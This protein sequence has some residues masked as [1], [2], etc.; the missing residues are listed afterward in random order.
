MNLSIEPIIK[1][2]V[3]VLGC[4]RPGYLTVFMRYGSGL[5]DG[6]IPTEIP[7]DLVPFGLR[8]PNSVFSV[9]YDRI[10]GQIIE[11]EPTVDT[12]DDQKSTGEAAEE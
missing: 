11:V 1:I 5:A 10:K 2:Q 8:M 6:G 3:K 9:V 7:M 12:T 4:L